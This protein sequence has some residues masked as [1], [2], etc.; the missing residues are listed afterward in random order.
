[1][2]TPFLTSRVLGDVRVKPASRARARTVTCLGLDPE[3]EFWNWTR[4]ANALDI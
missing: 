4:K 3:K 1:M 2:E